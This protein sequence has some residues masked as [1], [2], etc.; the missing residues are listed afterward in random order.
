MKEKTNDGWIKRNIS[1]IFFAGFLAIQ[2]P[3]MI[4][5]GLSDYIRHK[6]IEAIQ[7]RPIMQRLYEEKKRIEHQ[8]R[9]GN[10][11]KYLA[12]K[13]E[14]VKYVI[15]SLRL[16]GRIE[17]ILADAPKLKEQLEDTSAQIKGGY[18]NDPAL[19]KL[20]RQERKYNYNTVRY[21]P[22]LAPIFWFSGELSK[23]SIERFEPLESYP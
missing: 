1:G 21:N 4:N 15:S 23:D 18:E 8:I 11:L 20:H 5:A 17:E 7:N 9:D 16:S 12:E 13:D 3:S 2:V 10:S 14:N 6:E 22:L 19:M